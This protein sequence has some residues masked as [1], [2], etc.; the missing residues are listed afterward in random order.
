[1]RFLSVTRV[2][3]CALA[4]AGCKGPPARLSAGAADTVIVNGRQPVR[5]PVSVFDARGHVLSSRGTLFSRVSGTA[6]S[7]GSDGN[8]TCAEKGDATV[9]ASLASAAATILVLC[10]PIRDLRT[11]PLH[12]VVGDSAQPLPVGAIGM[13]GQPVSLLTGTATILDANVARLKGFS[14]MPRSPGKTV[15]GIRI[16]ENISSIKVTVYQRSPTLDV[17]GPEHPLVAVP[18]TLESGD[19]R[20]LTLHRGNYLIGLLPQETE[21]HMAVLGV[22][23][24][25]LPWER[26]FMCDVKDDA[27]I[28]AYRSWS[29][30]VSKPERAMIAVE[31]LS[32]DE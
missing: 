15:V 26:R 16:G 17:I 1:M 12:L 13:D 22:R 29:K 30:N 2:T 5:V 25:R 32:R 3:V 19:T 9:H 8:V 21:V 10:R 27:T 23:C 6:A 7:V 31:L 24:V 11:A 18:V 28:V 4:L 14:V 20:K